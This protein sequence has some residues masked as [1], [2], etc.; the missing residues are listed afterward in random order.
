MELPVDV[1]TYLQQHQHCMH[2]QQVYYT[3]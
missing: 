2:S 1:T 3:S